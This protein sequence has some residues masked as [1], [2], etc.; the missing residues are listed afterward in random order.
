MNKVNVN[1]VFISKLFLALLLLLT[2]SS[3][4]AIEVAGTRW[5]LVRDGW[6]ISYPGL[7]FASDGTFSVNVQENIAI[8]TYTINEN[9]V[10]LNYTT[11]YG[12][13]EWVPMPEKLTIYETESPFS[14]YKLI[15]E[16]GSEWISSNFR[17]MS[18]E[19]R[20]VNNIVVYS[21]NLTGLTNENARMR[22]GPG[23]Q[24]TYLNF[25]SNQG[26]TTSSITQGEYVAIYGRSEHRTLIDGVN[27]YWYFCSVMVGIGEYYYGWIWGGLIDVR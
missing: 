4:F 27:K 15:G 24:Y 21:L 6:P 7:F 14:Y 12:T 3:L 25:R 2:C 22:V 23:T 13:Y 26:N 10:T 5:N 9:D 17:P 18:E 20:M 11:I 1:H 19:R 8:G 16:D